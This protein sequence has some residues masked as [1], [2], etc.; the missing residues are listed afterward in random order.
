MAIAASFLMPSAYHLVLVYVSIALMF[1]LVCKKGLVSFL[2]LITFLYV[3]A[4]SFS[5]GTSVTRV[6]P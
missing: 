5:E 2:M 1:F 6:I 4:G 3:F